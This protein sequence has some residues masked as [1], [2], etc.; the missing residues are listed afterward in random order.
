MNPAANT[1][2]VAAHA[3]SVA[4][5][6]LHTTPKQNTP[7]PATT[8][9]M[10][11]NEDDGE[12]SAGSAESTCADPFP[13]AAGY[14]GGD[15]VARTD[16]SEATVWMFSLAAPVRSLHVRVERFALRA[17]RDDLRGARSE[18]GDECWVCSTR[19]ASGVADWI[20][21]Y[22]AL[23]CLKRASA[24]DWRLDPSGKRSGCHC[25]ARDRYAFF[26]AS[27]GAPGRRSRRA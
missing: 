9:A 7:T 18:G 19:R 14:A 4:S 11:R 27:I 22:A 10:C 15:E 3:S 5:D 8:I 16:R 12:F 25:P 21:S 13:A 1:A 26:T 23:I 20:C 24:A 6:G 2:H 17:I